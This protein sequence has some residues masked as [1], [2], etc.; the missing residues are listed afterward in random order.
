MSSRKTWQWCFFSQSAH[1]HQ[2]VFSR[3]WEK[4]LELL[5]KEKETNS[6]QPCDC[7][8]RFYSCPSL[9]RFTRVSADMKYVLYWIPQVKQNHT[10]LVLK[11]HTESLVYTVNVKESFASLPHTY[12]VDWTITTVWD[13]NRIFFKC[14]KKKFFVFNHRSKNQLK[15]HLDK[16]SWV[17]MFQQSGH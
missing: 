12:E 11:Q 8:R 10:Y 2:L 7:K 4:N 16:D 13:K 6:M 5:H 1:R 17:G 15:N 9:Y 14:K 3:V